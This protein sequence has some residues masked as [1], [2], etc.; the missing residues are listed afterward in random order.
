MRVYE[1]AKAL[2]LDNKEM[3]K[4]LSEL[5]IEVKSH[6]SSLEDVSV[7]T[8]K[9]KILKKPA[10]DAHKKT[11]PEKKTEKP[12]EKPS[13]KATEETKAVPPV[14]QPVPE[15][16]P[17]VFKAIKKIKPSPS[18]RDVAEALGIPAAEAVKTLISK[19]FML[20][21][22]AP[23]DD[24]IL[25]IFSEKYNVRFEKETAAAPRK[26]ISP[27]PK[28]PDKKKHQPKG[29]LLPRAPVVAVMGHVD[30]GKTTLLDSI[31]NTN[32]TAREAGGITQHIGASVVRHDNKKIVFLDTP[33]HEA[34]TAMRARG[35][36]ATDVVI[37]VVAA[38]DGIMPQT[39]EA[40][41]HVKAAGVPIV[42][43][44]NKVDKP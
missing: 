26:E 42:V 38:D 3:M 21:A 5:N 10:E 13:E 39:R 8:V 27:Q 33:G 2:E 37:L 22:P 16:T 20:A 44:V 34:F 1:L 28:H 40:I 17:P 35:A 23:A 36:Q 9:A 4:I 25:A 19:G 11:K 41:A 43:A 24:K 32:V 6:M 14:P 12:T 15:H 30:H 18:V 31:R 7:E 29:A